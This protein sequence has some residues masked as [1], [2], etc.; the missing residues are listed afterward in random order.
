MS[1]KHLLCAPTVNEKNTCA[2]GDGLLAPGIEWDRAPV[3]WPLECLLLQSLVALSPE[4]LHPGAHET[5]P[6]LG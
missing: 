1:I 4:Q 2:C 3:L 6:L 5:G